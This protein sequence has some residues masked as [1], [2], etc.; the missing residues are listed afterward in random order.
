MFLIINTCL[1][2]VNTYYRPFSATRTLPEPYYASPIHSTSSSHLSSIFYSFFNRF[3]TCF[4]TFSHTPNL[5]HIYPTNN[6]RLR[7]LLTIFNPLD[8][9]LPS[10]SCFWHK[11]HILNLPHVFH[12]CFHLSAP[13]TYRLRTQARVLK[14]STHFCSFFTYFMFIFVIFNIHQSFFAIYSRFNHL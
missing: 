13:L 2:T 11:T 10:F 14:P 4:H 3:L 12:N 8:V 1:L 6:T 5:R 7:S 9:K